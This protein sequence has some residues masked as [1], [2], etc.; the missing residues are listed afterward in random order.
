MIRILLN[1]LRG[2]PPLINFYED[3]RYV[4]ITPWIRKIRLIVLGISAFLFF[5]G[6]LSTTSSMVPALTFWIIAIALIYFQAKYLKRLK[7]WVENNFWIDRLLLEMIVTNGLFDERLQNSVWLSYRETQN[8]LEVIALKRGDSFSRKVENLE[9]EIESILGLPLIEKN[10]F[11]TR[12]EYS[13]LKYKPVRKLVDSLPKEDSSLSI[14]IYGDFVIDLRHNYSMLVS[15]ASGAG[16]SFF[17]YYWITRFISQTV[18]GKHAKL[19]AIDPK[20]SDLY[21]LCRTAGMP[22]ENYGTTNAEAF[23][24]VR[25]YLKEMERRMAIYDESSAFD[26]VGIDIG[27]EPTL[28]I[29]EEYSSL[30]ASL[31]TKEKKDFENKVAIIAQKARSL[32]MG[33]CIVMQQPRS[34]SLSTN[35]REQLVNSVFLGNPSKESAGMM[36]GTTDLPQV[37]GKGVGVYSI[38]RGNPKEFESPQFTEDVFDVILPVWEH[39]AKSYRTEIVK[40]KYF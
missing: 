9:T 31:D 35:I 19:F 21:K 34:D 39:V 36:F 12:V 2:E 15:G 1:R 25:S 13:L 8:T 16:K 40:E 33:I 3:Y 11:P 24:I 30:V 14:E 38:E 10:I 18:N 37:K 4:N 20:Q 7:M 5:V 17:S 29:I 28:L 22:T 26:S 27:L 32:S 6:I 23:K